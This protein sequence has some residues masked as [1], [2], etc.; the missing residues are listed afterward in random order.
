V[1]LCSSRHAF[2][3]KCPAQGTQQQRQHAMLRRFQRASTAP[4]RR[5]RCGYAYVSCGPLHAA[6]PQVCPSASS[7]TRERATA[8]RHAFSPCRASPTT[9]MP[10]ESEA[11]RH[12]ASPGAPAAGGERR[13][14]A[15]PPVLPFRVAPGTRSPPRVLQPSRPY[16]PPFTRP[17]KLPRAAPFSQVSAAFASR[18]LFYRLKAQVRR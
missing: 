17:A 15:P 9:G 16:R 14:S 13:N 3:R 10:G 1:S 6:P 18:E 11:Y 7:R 12:A 5:L 4:S 8:Q 2:R